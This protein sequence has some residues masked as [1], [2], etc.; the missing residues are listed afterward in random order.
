MTRGIVV[1]I[2]FITA[3]LLI[4]V[5][6]ECPEFHEYD[7]ETEVNCCAVPYSE[8]QTGCDEVNNEYFSEFKAQK[9]HKPIYFKN[10]AIGKIQLT[11]ILLC[12]F[13]E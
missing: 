11:R 10:H 6:G 5:Q 1:L 12:V 7:P 2:C 3:L 13:R 4:P 9:S 8:T